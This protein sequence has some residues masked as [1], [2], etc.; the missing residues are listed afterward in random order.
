MSDHSGTERALIA[1]GMHKAAIVLA[2]D[3]PWLAS[4]VEQITANVDDIGLCDTPEAPGLYLFTGYARRMFYGL[5]QTDGGI[6][7]EGTVRPVTPDELPSLLA[8]RP[9][10]SSGNNDDP[11]L[12][13]GA[14]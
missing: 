8:M 10:E 14:M 2:T 12:C 5:E 11:P 9:P 7:W 6:V 3:G 4:D 1:V 13:E